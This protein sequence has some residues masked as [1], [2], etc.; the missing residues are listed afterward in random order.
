MIDLYSGTPGS[1]KSLHVASRVYYWLRLNR[2]CICNFEINTALISKKKH[3]YPFEMIDNDV[4]TPDY[5]ISFSRNYFKGKTVRE[6]SILLVLDECQLLFN[7]REWQKN[8]RAQWLSFFT[9]HRKYGYH[10]ILVAQFDRMIDR[11]IRSLIEYEYIHRKVSNFGW[12]GKIFSLFALGNLF[13]AVKVWY[14]MSEKVGSEFFRAHKRF[15]RLYDTYGDFGTG[16]RLEK[17][18]AAG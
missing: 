1:G 5:L 12:R 17:G 16:N 9:Q 8:G 10:I 7:A 6:D 18:S 11:Q 13:V 4:L 15:Y 2:P 3:S 14:P